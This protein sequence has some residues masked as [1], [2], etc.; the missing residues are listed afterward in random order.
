MWSLA[1]EP[2]STRPAAKPFFR[3]LYELAK[4]LD[5]TRPVTVVSCIGTEEEAFEFC[6]VVCL[7]RYFGWYTQAGQLEQACALLSAELDA[8]H[9]RFPKP[10]LLT[11]FG[12]DTIAGWHAQPPEMF[13]EEY[14]VEMLTRYIEVL[15]S[16]SYVVGQHVWNMCDFKTAQAVRRVGGMNLKGVFTRDRRPKLAAHRL[17]ELWNLQE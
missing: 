2:H 8:L 16:K 7:N 1:N 15:N 11:E 3:E 17:R 6:D 4:S 12:A 9:A 14:Q 5:P 10:L 13:S